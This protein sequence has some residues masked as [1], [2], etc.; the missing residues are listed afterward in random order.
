MSAPPPNKSA[1][2]DIIEE[3]PINKGLFD[4]LSAI[5]IF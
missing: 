4:D 3:K 2:L 1:K 5:Q